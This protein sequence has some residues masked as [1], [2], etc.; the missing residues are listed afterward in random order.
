M[1][2]HQRMREEFRHH[3]FTRHGIKFDDEILILLIRISQMHRDL[4]REI[5]RTPPLQFRSGRDYLF[6][7]VGRVAGVTISLL[8]LVTLLVLIF[9]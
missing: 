7:G 6:Y 3:Y 5:R 9:R 4:R 8:L 2:K 1:D